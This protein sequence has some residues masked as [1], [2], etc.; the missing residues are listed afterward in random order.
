M[1]GTGKR[2]L[3]PPRVVLSF[4]VSNVLKNKLK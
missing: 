3:V 4:K 2:L 1:P